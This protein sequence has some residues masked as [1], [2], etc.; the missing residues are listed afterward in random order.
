M[1]YTDFVPEKVQHLERMVQLGKPLEEGDAAL[2]K[3]HLSA[4]AMLNHPG[5]DF[6][7]IETQ[8]YPTARLEVAQLK[9]RQARWA[10]MGPPRPEPVRR[11]EFNGAFFARERCPVSARRLVQ[12]TLARLR[13]QD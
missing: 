11:P 1:S 13:E 10:K 7:Q 2:L 8:V 3:E 9:E 4:K 5:F 6:G 12:K